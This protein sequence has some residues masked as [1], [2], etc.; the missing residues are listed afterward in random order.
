[1]RDNS[2]CVFYLK[3]GKAQV[4]YA[5]A[6]RPDMDALKR[7]DDSIDTANKKHPYWH[8]GKDL[9]SEISDINTDALLG[10]K[11]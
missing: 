4:F 2:G 8:E 5:N 9:V 3:H 11:D 6:F 7:R 1:M 10:R